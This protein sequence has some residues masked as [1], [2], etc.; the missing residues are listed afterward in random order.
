[1]GVIR[2]DKW[3]MDSY[4][5][6]IDICENLEKYFDGASA[7]EIYNYLLSHGMYRQPSR[8]GNNEIVDH[9]KEKKVWHIVQDES[10]KLRKLWSGP[11]IPIFI[12]P[13]D[14]SNRKLKQDFNGKSGL[15][16]KNKLFLFISNEN[17]EEEIRALFAH[18]YNHICRLSKFKKSEKDYVLL[19]TIILEGLAENAVREKFGEEYLANWTA[20]YSNEE[21]KKLFNHLI[22]PKKDVHNQERKHQEILYGLRFYPKMVGY[23]VGYYL[24][25]KYIDENNTLSKDLLSFPTSKIAQIKTE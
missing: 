18:E 17:K 25:K 21:L 24:V 3:L 15:A 5:K 19:D 8:N 7:S 11:N 12:F 10:Q 2:T 23:S 16:F 14:T 13:S 1:M 4:D 22:L 6:P 20:Y 9:L